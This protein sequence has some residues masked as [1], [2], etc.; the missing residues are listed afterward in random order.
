MSPEEYT[1]RH[2]HLLGCFSLHSYRYRDPV[3]GAWVR[4]LG[5]ILSSEDEV[6][7]CRQEFLTPE[8]LTIVRKQEREGL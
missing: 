5:E 1:A 2:A 6:E 8:E 3:L 4:R 7:R